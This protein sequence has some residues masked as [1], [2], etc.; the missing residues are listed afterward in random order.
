MRRAAELWAMARQT[1]QPT[2]GDKAIDADIM[3]VAEALMFDSPDAIIATR[4]VRHLARFAPAE[5]WLSITP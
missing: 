3:I 5:F 2:A 1:G 4:N